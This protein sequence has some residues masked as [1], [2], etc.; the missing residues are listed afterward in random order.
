MKFRKTLYNQ[1]TIEIAVGD[2]ARWTR[3]DKELGRRNGQEFT[4]TGI[5]GHT[6]T[7]ELQGG[8][9]D[10]I[11]L[12]EPLHLD[13][14][15]VATTYS[16]Q[17]KTA[18]RVLV[19]STCDATVSSESVYV[20]IS[21]AK[22]DLKIYAEDIDY[23]LEQAQESKAQKTVL[24]LLQPSSK[25]QVSAAPGRAVTSSVERSVGVTA[26]PKVNFEKESTAPNLLLRLVACV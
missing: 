16:S 7:I 8:K 4:V 18:N 20:A 14:A 17:G 1:E 19:S 9:T 24:E 22:Y 23:L 5:D 11:D 25:V 13:H 3:N 15:L 12:Y 21:R 10:T 6:A 2:R 26:T